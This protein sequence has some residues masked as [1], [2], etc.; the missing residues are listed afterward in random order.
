MLTRGITR[1]L[2]LLVIISLAVPLAD[3]TTLPAIAKNNH[4][5]AQAQKSKQVH[6]EKSKTETFTNTGAITIPAG[7]PGTTEGPA[8]PFPSTIQASGFKKGR[9]QDVNITLNGFSHTFPGD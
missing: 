4:H 3:M 2:A 7:A 9:L 6:A 1:V 8:N 5:S